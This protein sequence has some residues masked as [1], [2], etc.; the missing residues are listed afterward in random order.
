M[1]SILVAAIDDEVNISMYFSFTE[2][3]TKEHEVK[4]ALDVD[5]FFPTNHFLLAK[6][7]DDIVSC[8]FNINNIL[9]S[10]FDP[11]IIVPPPEFN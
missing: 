2:E 6:S 3:E 4:C 9:N 7:F 11:G 5:D 1:P 10:L 8:K